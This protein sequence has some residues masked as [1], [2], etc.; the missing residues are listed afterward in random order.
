MKILII[1]FLLFLAG[2]F[3]GVMDAL[4]FHN[5]CSYFDNNQFW[6]PNQSWV[7]KWA[8]DEE[9][10]AIVGEERFFGSSTAFVFL[11]DGW[12]LAKFL[13]LLFIKLALVVALFWEPSNSKSKLF[14]WIVVIGLM[15]LAM[16]LG[17]HTTYDL[18]FHN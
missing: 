17:F 13:Q 9:G 11:T 12:H 4:Q 16:S 8:L 18:I 6:C 5:G 15:T 1:L 7:N 14:Q 10:N 2:A 3:N